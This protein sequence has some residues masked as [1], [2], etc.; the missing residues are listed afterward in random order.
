MKLFLDEN[1]YSIAAENG[2]SRDE[3]D[4]RFYEQAKSYEKSVGAKEPKTWREIAVENGISAGTFDSR[5]NLGWRRERA[6][7]EK[8]H[9]RKDNRWIEKAKKNNIPKST[10]DSRI[11]QKGWSY[12]EAATTPSMT[13]SQAGSLSQ[14]VMEV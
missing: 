6:A 4:K 14:R 11:Y 13:K 10:Y 5:V 2:I 3:A 8:V 12:E 7:T 1:D 9:K